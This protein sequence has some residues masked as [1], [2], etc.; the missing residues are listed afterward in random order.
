MTILLLF[1]ADSSV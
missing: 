1:W